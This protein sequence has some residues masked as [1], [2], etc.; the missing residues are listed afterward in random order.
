MLFY[1]HPYQTPLVFRMTHTDVR[2][3]VFKTKALKR[4]STA[5]YVLFVAV[6][7]FPH[8]MLNNQKLRLRVN[9]CRATLE[10]DRGALKQAA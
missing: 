4:A 2:Y 6:S 7:P 5:L 3:G 1:E 8:F 9:F 10:R